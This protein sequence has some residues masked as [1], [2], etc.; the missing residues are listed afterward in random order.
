MLEGQD[1]TNGLTPTTTNHNQPSVEAIEEFTLQTSNFAAEF[2]QV[3][4]GL[5]NFTA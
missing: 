1:A 3:N 4:G 5:F 2:G